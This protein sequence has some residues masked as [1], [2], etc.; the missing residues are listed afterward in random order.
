M[1]AWRS[2]MMPRHACSLNRQIIHQRGLRNE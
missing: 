2:L 1:S